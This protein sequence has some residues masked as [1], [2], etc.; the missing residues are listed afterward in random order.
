MAAD[1]ERA[2]FRT[3]AWRIVPFVCLLYVLN[4]L[5]RANVG[6]ARL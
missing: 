6:F 5:D 4:I 1:L 3:V 2:T